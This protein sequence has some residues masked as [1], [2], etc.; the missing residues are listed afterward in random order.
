MKKPVKAALLLV[1]SASF[2]A[3]CNNTQPEESSLTDD[4]S[5]AS[6]SAASSSASSSSS[7]SSESSND[8]S[9]AQSTADT[10]TEEGNYYTV[11]FNSN[12]GTEVDPQRVKEGEKATKPADPTKE[13]STFGGWF[14]SQSLTNE[15]DFANTAITTDYELFA[16][17][18][19]PTQKAQYWIAN[20]VTG[21]EKDGA[22]QM[23]LPSEGDDLA[24][25]K[26]Y[27]VTAGFE[28]KITDFAASDQKWIGYSSDLSSLAVKGGN[29][30]LNVVIKRAG[31]YDFALT[32][33]FKIKVSK[34][35][36]SE[37]D[38]KKADYWLAGNGA[39]TIGTG[40]FEML[41]DPT[42]AN[43]AVL[44]GVS[45]E[46]GGQGYKVTNF[47]SEWYGCRDELS[48][49]AS[50]G[51]DNNIVIAES[52]KYNV[53]LNGSSQVW[54]EWVSHTVSFDS[55][56]GSD[57]ASLSVADGKNAVKPEDPTKEG[58][59]FAG[60]YT[61]ENLTSVFVFES[62]P[63]TGDLT[64]YAKWTE[65]KV[66]VTFDTDGA[67]SI[68]P[69]ELT[70]GQS[71]S[72]PSDP[73]KTG[74]NFQY[75]Y[76][77]SDDTASFDFASAIRSDIT[78]HAKWDIIVNEVTFKYC[79]GAT[80]DLVKRVNYGDKVEK[81]GKPTRAGY[82]F[83]GWYTA[84]TEGAEFDFEETEI[85]AG[86]TLYGR[87]E[88]IP[89]HT[90]SFD[91]NEGTSVAAQEVP[92]GECATRPDN[93]TKVGYVFDNWY[94]SEDEDA[95]VFDFTSTI[96][97]D[98]TVYAKW[99][100]AYFNVVF[101]TNCDVAAETKSVKYNG[102]VD[103]PS[104]SLSKTG[105]T[106]AGWY[107]DEDCSDSC[108]FAIAS[109][110]ITESID[111]Y[112]KWEKN[113]YTITF[114]SEEGSDVEPMTAKYGD[115]IESPAAPTKTG[116]AFAGWYTS[117]SY[118]AD[119]KFAFGED[120]ITD[121]ID[122]YA[123]WETPRKVSFDYGDETETAAI[124]PDGETV[125]E[126]EEPT[127][128]GYVF[129]YWYIKDGDGTAY[130]FDTP[131]TSDI[132]LVAKW[133]ELSDYYITGSFSEWKQASSA[134]MEKDSAGTNLAV[135]ENFVV[136][137]GT[138][139]K[140]TDFGDGWYGYHS[141]ISNVASGE[142]GGNI[143]VNESGTYNFYLNSSKEVW[144]SKVTDDSKASYWLVGS[145]CGWKATEGAIQMDKD[146]SDNNLAVLKGYHL[147]KGATLKIVDGKF[148]NWYGYYDDLSAVASG[149][150]D[151]DIT[152]TETGDYD[153]YLNSGSKVWIELSK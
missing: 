127:Q 62:T 114:Y 66:T 44:Y 87:W 78:L 101:H 96:T 57:V 35:S 31:T 106:F 135:L 6:S 17:W 65:K 73:V 139:L 52:G 146:S 18:N 27:T 105:H 107:T 80:A 128:D 119:E 3:S 118:G 151:G 67:G 26:N 47:D 61:D 59:D 123:R 28:F 30:G 77:D 100:D 9:T 19:V 110:P 75:W 93:P 116:Y 88:A 85:V 34:V 111:L 153:I 54:V 70:Y 42:D 125:E 98:V 130:S 11:S 25:L 68:D 2:L 99:S 55:K 39:W 92:D 138:T 13:G 58:F 49:V 4:T 149:V 120:I 91:A 60:W 38:D 95:Q 41:K 63:V 150:K 48:G 140:V 32:S 144:I 40:A 112:A 45:L 94:V 82:A 136:D 51:S 15:F 76:E 152:I 90:V 104:S 1:V 124:V 84:E 129:K 71:A 83:K 24:V 113:T 74:Y 126:P 137:A 79:D 143:T 16:K 145:F 108:S 7:S 53:Y 50:A 22:V 122:L 64:L 86:I 56:G 81:P 115:T 109:T 102:N 103:D 141:G 133:A 36:S 21:W 134:R 46:A 14:T 132:S 29:D 10:S 8:T 12:G 89:T 142:I 37:E 97:S 148:Q 43:K 5:E 33:D 121:N 147:E 23:D 131:V 69:L 72:K 20:S 117:A